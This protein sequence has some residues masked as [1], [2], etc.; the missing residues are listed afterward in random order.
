M[1]G[2][3]HPSCLLRS[4]AWSFVVDRSARRQA[5]LGAVEQVS[6]QL[7]GELQGTQWIAR[8]V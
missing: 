8:C 7:A 6:A 4:V 3:I 2:A 5:L 1:Q